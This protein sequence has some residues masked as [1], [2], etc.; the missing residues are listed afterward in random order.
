MTWPTF[1]TALTV[2]IFFSA[3][4]SIA[5]MNGTT[6]HCIRLGIL[7]ILVA[8]LGQALGAALTEWEPYLDTLLYCGVLILLL[9]NRRYR[10][11]PS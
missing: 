5:K 1:N 3:I 8:S 7:L 11:P 10:R 6:R 4:W 2:V 9:F